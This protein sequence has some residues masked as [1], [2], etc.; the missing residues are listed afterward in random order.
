MVINSLND[1]KPVLHKSV[2]TFEGSHIIGDVKIG[3]NSSV[4]Y[5]AVIRGGIKDL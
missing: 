5:N 4:W 3:E 2:R 1:L